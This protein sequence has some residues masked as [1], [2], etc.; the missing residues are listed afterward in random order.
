MGNPYADFECYWKL[1][2][3]TPQQLKCGMIKRVQNEFKNCRIYAVIG[4][5][6]LIVSNG[7]I[8]KS[9]SEETLRTA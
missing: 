2:V 6:K 8:Q 7:Q 9:G 1:V 5:E 4:E 3:A